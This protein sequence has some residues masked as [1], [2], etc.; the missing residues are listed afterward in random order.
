MGFFLFR[1]TSTCNYIAWLY[2]NNQD[3][4]T[5]HDCWHQCCEHKEEHAEEQEAG[6]VQPFTGLVPDPQVQQ[7]NQNAHSQVRDQT[8]PSQC[9]K[10]VQVINEN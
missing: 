1:Y 5:S 4:L 7:T 10:F 3:L 8:Q 6:I 9:L 2:C